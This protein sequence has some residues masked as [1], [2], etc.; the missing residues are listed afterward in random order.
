MR[1]QTLILV[2]LGLPVLVLL[3]LALRR[4]RTDRDWA[5]DM[6][7]LVRPEVLADGRVRL[8]GVRDWRY[9]PDSVVSTGTLDGVW[10]PADLTDLWMYEQVFDE[11][12]LTA[13]TFLVFE[14][15]ESYGERR[16]LGVSMEARREADEA[17]SILR[18]MFR[19]YEAAMI[20]A[21]EEDLATRR[22]VYAGDPVNR[23]RLEV[24]P[25]SRASIFVRMAEETRALVDHPRW[26]NTAFY[27]CTSSLIRYANESRPGAIP[28]HYSWV[29]TGRIDEHLERLGYLDTAATRTLTPE[30]VRRDGLRAEG[31]T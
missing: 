31:R 10:D 23:Y 27:N 4:P 14:F 11:R 17:Y 3:L 16:F 15:D 5:P 12:G 6:Q 20:W 8:D 1:G 22:L 19:S 30:D 18:G 13:H 2:L 29:L 7:R 28:L 21:T 25:E 9:A 26:Y 24:D